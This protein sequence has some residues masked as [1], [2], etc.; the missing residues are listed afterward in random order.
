VEEWLTALWESK[1]N[2][3]F[4][5]LVNEVPIIQRIKALLSS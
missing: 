3:V 2:S 4:K 5:S 1:E